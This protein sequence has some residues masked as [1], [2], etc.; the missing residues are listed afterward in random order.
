[1]KK[2]HIESLKLCCERYEEAIKQSQSQ[3]NAFTKQLKQANATIEKLIRVV[4]NNAK[5]SET[6]LKQA[7]VDKWK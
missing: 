1:M 7:G 3:I 4:N 5:N 6:I 2:L